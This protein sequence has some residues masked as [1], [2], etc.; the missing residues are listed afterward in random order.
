MSCL[1]EVYAAGSEDMDALTFGA[2][3]LLRHL[4]FSEAK[5]MPITEFHLD[6][7]LEGLR[8]NMA[9]FIDLCILLGCDYCDGIRG[10]G[11]MRAVNLIQQHG[12][13]EGIIEAI[14]RDKYPVPE[15][16]PYQH[17]RHLF[18]S[19]E[20]VTGLAEPLKWGMPDTEALVDFMVKQNGFS[21]VRVRTAISKM[22]KARKTAPQGRLDTFFKKIEPE[23]SDKL[24]APAKKQSS[25]KK[26][27][28]TL[29]RAKTCA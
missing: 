3:V 13:I 8:L 21:E 23:A 14:D 19:P 6:K 22:V 20:V 11:P 26:Q 27:P 15:E 24:Q 7:V 16:W 12:C 1:G 18:Q 17:V 2:T 25:A 4:T 9:Q 28:K 29:K 10:I 5:K